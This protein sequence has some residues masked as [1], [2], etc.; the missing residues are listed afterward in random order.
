MLIADD[1]TLVRESLKRL[2]SGTRDIV[3]AGEASSGDRVLELLRPGGFDLLLLDVSMPGLSGEELMRRVHR[4]LPE[5]P[6]LV[7]SMYD[8]PRVVRRK[9]KAGA[10][11]YLTKDSEPEVLLAA[12]R[13]VAAGGRFIGQALAERIAFEAQSELVSLLFERLSRRERQVLRLLVEGHSLRDIAARL[14][15]SHKTV[16]SHKARLM[17]KLE[18]D[19]DA[20][21][22]RLAFRNRI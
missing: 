9:L 13:K 15:I 19:S 21:L 11:G 2:F 12:V 5:L 4:R 6:I 3:V 18:V 22:I 17:Q 8:E 14:V 1:H 16:S 20:E 7:L 10:A